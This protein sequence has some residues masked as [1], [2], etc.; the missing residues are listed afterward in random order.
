MSGKRGPHLACGPPELIAI[1]V[2]IIGAPAF[3]S[4]VWSWIKRWFDPITV[5]KI[6]ILSPHEVLPTLSKYVDPKNIPKQYGGELDFAFGDLPVPD[7]AWEGIVEWDN[8]H[9]SFPTGPH[10]WRE[11]DEG[12]RVE[13]I[14]IGCVDGKDRSE[15]ICSMPKNYWW[16][17]VK[18]GQGESKGQKVEA[19]A[20]EVEEPANAADKPLELADKVVKT[21]IMDEA[22][23]V[24]AVE[25][26]TKEPN[27]KPA[28]INEKDV[29]RPLDSAIPTTVI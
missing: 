20:P 21:T 24:V 2:Q 29:R 9:K 1:V 6:L 13:C 14:G 12:K 22:D 17:A 10:V 19:A 16:D 7:P 4:T 26:V 8:G 18:E 28:E 27:G 11:T 23:K 15:R 25:P 5:S 3:F